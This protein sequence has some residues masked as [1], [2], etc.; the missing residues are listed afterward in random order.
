MSEASPIARATLIDAI[1]LQIQDLHATGRLNDEQPLLRIDTREQARNAPF[2]F[3][4]AGGLLHRA[5]CKASPAGTRSA[6][7]GVWEV[8]AEDPALA[9]KVCEPLGK[10]EAAPR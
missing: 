9:C 2:Q 4:A 1:G 3:A 5:G 10:I 8:G 6:L 7:Y